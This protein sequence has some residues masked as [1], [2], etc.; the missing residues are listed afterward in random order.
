MYLQQRIQSRNY[1]KLQQKWRHDRKERIL[2]RSL[3]GIYSTLFQIPI[4]SKTRWLVQVLDD[5]PQ[6]LQKYAVI[7]SGHDRFLPSPFQFTI[8]QSSYHS[9]LYTIYSRYWQHCK[10]NHKKTLHL[11]S[12]T[13]PRI[14][15]CGYYTVPESLPLTKLSKDSHSAGALNLDCPL[16]DRSEAALIL[17]RLHA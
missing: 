16:V 15:V 10:I 8:Y 13:R 6:S 14:L 3:E 5:F 9:T 17:N 4:S 7:V 1:E 2:V 12:D 11:I